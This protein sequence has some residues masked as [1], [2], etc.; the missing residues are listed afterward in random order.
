[1]RVS[2]NYLRRAA[3]IAE[4]QNTTRSSLINRFIGEGL[5]REEHRKQ[6]EAAE[7]GGALD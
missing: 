4:L 1:M 6:D 7:T 3:R 5:R 2:P